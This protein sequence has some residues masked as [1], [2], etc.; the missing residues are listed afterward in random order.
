[1][2]SATKTYCVVARSVYFLQA[3]SNQYLFTAQGQRGLGALAVQIVN[4]HYHTRPVASHQKNLASF[5]FY[6]QPLS[7]RITLRAVQSFFLAYSTLFN[8][9]CDPFSVQCLSLGYNSLCSRYTHIYKKVIQFSS[10][11]FMYICR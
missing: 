8:I 3:P 2:D 10:F 1:M 7:R 11:I 6:L 4:Y 9:T 5:L